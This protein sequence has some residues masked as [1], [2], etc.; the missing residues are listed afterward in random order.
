LDSFSATFF[1]S[2][3][4][5][6]YPQPNDWQCGPFALK[7]ALLMLGKLVDEKDISRHAGAN[8][9]SGSDEIQLGK[10]ARSFDTRLIMIRRHDPEQARKEMT[11]YLRRGIP[12]LLCVYDWSHWVTVVK[13]EKGKYILLDSKDKAVLTILTWNQLKNIWV[14]YEQDEQDKKFYRTIYD[15]HP[16]V[17]KFRIKSK[18][19]FSLAKAKYL[20][21]SEN[22]MLSRHW[23]HFIED[24]LAICKPRTPLSENVFSLGEFLRR[25]GE[26]IVDQLGY[27]HGWINERQASRL[28]RHMRFVA[29]TYGLVI[30][31]EEEKRAITGITAILSLWAAAKFGVQ[32]VYETNSAKHRRRR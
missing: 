10:A 6:L 9:W 3:S 24:L 28:L 26:M 15:F 18:A 13:S 11:D 7:H 19:S 12:S 4:M 2:T 30:H 14:Y 29:D 5:G 32:P 17:P 20:R 21:R 1:E 27:W 31:E 23:D 8:W 16:V 22:R 25:H